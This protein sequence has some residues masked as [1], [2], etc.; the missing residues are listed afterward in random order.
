[1]LECVS[2]TNGGSYIDYTGG[3]NL[4]NGTGTVDIFNINNSINQ[5]LFNHNLNTNG[6]SNNNNAIVNNA[7]LNQNSTCNVNSV[8]N[9]FGALMFL[10]YQCILVPKTVHYQQQ[11]QQAQDYKQLVIYLMDV[12]KQHCSITHEEFHFIV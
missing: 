2:G 1:M 4:R 8:L 5:G 11:H 6:I 3:I 9:V 7:V 12:V 10:Q